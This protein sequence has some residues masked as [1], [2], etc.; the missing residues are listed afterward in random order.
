M[1]ILL[2]NLFLLSLVL[3]QSDTTYLSYYP[4]NVGD[5]REYQRI[6]TN[7]Q[8]SPI[9]EY[10]YFSTE[11][12]GDT[13][14]PNGIL[15]KIIVHRSIPDTSTISLSFER[16]DTLTGNVYG[17]Y[18]YKEVE[19][20]IDSLQMQPGDSAKASRSGWSESP[21]TICNQVNV[22][23]VLGQVCFV[24]DFT[25]MSWYPGLHYYLASG[26]GLI[27][28]VIAENWTIHTTLIYARINGKEFGTP[29]NVSMS[30]NPPDYFTL[31]QNYPNPFNPETNIRINIFQPMDISLIL[32]DISG[33]KVRLL[34]EGRVN[35]GN[36]LYVLDGSELS[37]GIYFYIIKSKNIQA[38]KKCILIK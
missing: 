21:L 37:S 22:D 13:L 27:Y 20:L 7:W 6:S 29:V 33:R 1:R 31:Y 8:V 3:A 4:L 25:D 36:H 32:Y 24:K 16:F 23:T 38:T 26:L 35:I 10:D 15:N 14:L 18:G 9:P 34:F 2:L 30:N 12:I 28:S 17:Y 5:Y 11:I 19:Y